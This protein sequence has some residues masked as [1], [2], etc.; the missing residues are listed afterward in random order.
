MVDLIIALRPKHTSSAI[1][2]PGAPPSF[3]TD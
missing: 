1:I 3:I 2:A